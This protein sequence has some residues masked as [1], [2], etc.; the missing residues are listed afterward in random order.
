MQA[1]VGP[2]GEEVIPPPFANLNMPSVNDGARPTSEDPESDAKMTR[3]MKRMISLAR[4]AACTPPSSSAQG[5]S[6]RLKKSERAL[7]QQWNS[8]GKCC[9]SQNTDILLFRVY[10]SNIELHA[11]IV[12]SAS[13]KLEPK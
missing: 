11:N 3:T 1:K 10:Q 9:C 7:L 4:C 13:M 8:P 2:A 12:L 5:N 6:P